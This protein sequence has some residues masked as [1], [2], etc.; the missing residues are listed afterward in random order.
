MQ[1]SF[2]TGEWVINAGEGFGIDI[3]FTFFK[4]SSSTYAW[5]SVITLES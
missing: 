4:V 5:A 1:P 3:T 2:G